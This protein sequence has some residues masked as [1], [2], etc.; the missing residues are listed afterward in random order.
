MRSRCDALLVDP[1]T[2]HEKARLVCMGL[3]GMASEVVL[4]TMLPKSR[5]WLVWWVGSK[6][7]LRG[8]AAG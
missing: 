3:A 6:K 8:G 1:E 5:G 4:A 2:W 7:P